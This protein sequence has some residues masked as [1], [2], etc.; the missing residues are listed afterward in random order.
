MNPNLEEE[1]PFVSHRT[2]VY[3]PMKLTEAELEGS[4]VNGNGL[5]QR[6][7]SDVTSEKKKSRPQHHLIIGAPGDG[8]TANLL[9]LE[10]ELKAFQGRNRIVPILLAEEIY[11][12]DRLSKFWLKCLDALAEFCER[13]GDLECASEIDELVQNHQRSSGPS[14]DLD[15]FAAGELHRYFRSFADRIERRPVLLVDN[16]QMLFSQTHEQQHQF[17]QMLTDIAAP[18]LVGTSPFQLPELDDYHFAFFDHFKIYHLKPLSFEEFFSL[19]V[20]LAKQAQRDDVQSFVEASV[21]RLKATY[22]LTGGSPRVAVMLYR[23]YESSQKGAASEDLERL[24]D[25]ATPSCKFQ[26]EQLSNQQ[27]AILAEIAEHWAP[28]DNPTLSRLTG[29]SQ[30]SVS[31]QLDRLRKMGMVQEVSLYGT[32]NRGFQI[33]N[34]LLNLWFLM[35]LASRRKRNQLIRLIRFLDP[36]H[37]D[38]FPF[39]SLSCR[40]IPKEKLHNYHRAEESISMPEIVSPVKSQSVVDLIRLAA[41]ALDKGQGRQLIE[42]LKMRGEEGRLRPYF[43][44]LQAQQKNEKRA[45]ANLEVETRVVSENLFDQIAELRSQSRNGNPPSK[46][47]LSE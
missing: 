15:S 34:R 5:W 41:E 4:F 6:I 21:G 33:R 38:A 3:N 13:E 47:D 43:E 37:D 27:R 46:L 18:I 20:V 14:A 19:I 7:F 22:Q 45:L 16:V 11:F 24:L 31:C 12:V 9:K 30:T 44:A 10:R 32:R 26:F 1:S 28:I 25:E 29:L 23:L 8:K 2:R 36:R 17:R 39:E 35:R 40:R 42:L